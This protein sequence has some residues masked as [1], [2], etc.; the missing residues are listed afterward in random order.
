MWKFC[1][2]KLC[3]NFLLWFLYF[4]PSI[5]SIL[6]GIPIR[7]ILNS[8][9]YI[10]CAFFLTISNPL[11]F[12]LCSQRISQLALTAILYFV[13]LCYLAQILFFILTITG[14]ISKICF[15]DKDVTFLNLWE[16]SCSKSFSSC[17][18]NWVFQY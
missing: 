12:P 4:L 18:I 9:I 8:W 1:P 3:E 10:P 16:Y 5:F 15:I 6:S 13:S 2:F 7:Q 11:T 17:C 14:L